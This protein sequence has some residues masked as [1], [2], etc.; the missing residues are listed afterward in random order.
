MRYFRLLISITLLSVL[1]LLSVVCDSRPNHEG[2]TN[3]LDPENPLT[4]GDPFNLQAEYNEGAVSLDW[5][6]V[7]IP[8]MQGYTIS[9][10]TNLENAF[11]T[12]DTVDSGTTGWQDSSPAYF[13]TSLYR[14]TLIG[15]DGGESDTTG[16]GVDTLV[17]P[18]YLKIADG[19][20]TTALAEVTVSIR[21]E[22]AE[23]MRLSADSLMSETE[24]VAFLTDTVWV[25]DEEYC[26][27]PPCTLSLYLQVARG[28]SDTSAVITQTIRS[29]SI[30]G[31]IL[32]ADGDSSIAR[33]RVEVALSAYRPTRIVLGENTVFGDAG[34]TTI[35]FDSLYTLD[36]LNLHWTF[37]DEL[38]TKWLYAEFQNDF[39]TETLEV[40]VEP[41]LMED[42]SIAFVWDDSITSECDVPVE[43]H[44]KALLM[45]LAGTVHE[46]SQEDWIP[47]TESAAWTVGDT[48]GI[49]TV[50]A[51]FQ[52]EFFTR[53]VYDE[54]EFVPTPLTVTIVSPED[55]L[56]IEI[57]EENDTIAV[58]GNV[59]AASCRTAPDS[60]ELL[61]DT[62]AFTL[63]ATDT[64]WTVDWIVTE[65]P[66]DTTSVSVI[67]RTE[68][69]YGGVAADTVL[70][71]IHP[72]VEDTTGSEK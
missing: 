43:L 60:V 34:D 68:D 49:Y 64:G 31:E 7:G 19:A 23:W 18:P 72:V 1:A 61:I 11:A 35:V 20:E 70:F 71:F 55:S 27:T 42:A 26:A 6:A 9:R 10:K 58:S 53:Y 67:A 4:G 37:S 51:Q 52:N 56:M 63:A 50:F 65:I 57:V 36:P 30:G 45:R 54:I 69:D 17:V 28:G 13:T 62:T 12:L 40:S 66:A 48:A 46:I 14:V 16:R 3:P 15:P 41:D 33:T 47:Y 38:T 29:A 24:W 5:A 32:L 25:I 2:P 44:A 21:A 39:V 59:V 8:G 22:E